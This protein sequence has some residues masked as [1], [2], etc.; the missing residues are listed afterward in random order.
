MKV[1][2]YRVSWEHKETALPL[3]GTVVPTTICR[4]W[5]PGEGEEKARILHIGVTHCSPHD[6]YDKDKGRK[7][8]LKQA[9]S[10]LKLELRVQFWEAYRTMTPEPR[11]S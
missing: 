10:S 6:V 5:I 8:S 7:E 2:K 9:I 1:D 4:V 3:S 11:W